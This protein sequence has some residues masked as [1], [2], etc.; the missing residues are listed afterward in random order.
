MKDNLFR[1]DGDLGDLVAALPTMRALGGGHLIIAEGGGSIRESLRGAR[2]ESI[3]PL[4][5]QQPYIHGLE[6][7]PE[8]QGVTHDFSTFRHNEIRG[9]NLA[10]WQ[11]RHFG[12]SVSLAPWLTVTP[13]TKAQGR[14]VVANSG[15]CRNPLFPW[16]RLLRFHYPNSLFVGLPD[17]HEDFRYRTSTR[18]EFLPTAN[19][20]ELAEVIAGCQLFIG[21]QSC[22]FWIAAALGVPLIQEVWP[23]GPNSM[24]ERPNAQYWMLPPEEFQ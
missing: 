24:V 10:R 15:R 16:T 12:L 7:N 6:W 17:E 23:Q 18:T 19:L 5:L 9:E 3:K 13:S 4:L 1:H 11:A 14:V 22:P 2:F 20:L 21:N 8:P